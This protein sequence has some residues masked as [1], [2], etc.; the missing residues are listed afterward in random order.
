MNRLS[1]SP[2]ISI[3]LR[4]P[5]YLAALMLS[6]P[7]CAVS[8]VLSTNN[9]YA[10]TLQNNAILQSRLTNQMI[11]LG[12]KP[13][14]SSGSRVCLPPIDLQRGTAG[15]VPPALQGDPRYQEYLH[16]RYGDVPITQAMAN[17]PALPVS[18]AL[19]M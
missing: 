18:P 6:M 8:Q 7:I 1:M 13:T 9:P 19:G 10:A 15:L 2:E 14:S 3:A 4:Q 5:L 17:A 11:N 16:C 12:G